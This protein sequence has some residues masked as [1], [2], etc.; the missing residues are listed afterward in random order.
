MPK[1]LGINESTLKKHLNKLKAALYPAGGRYPEALG[2]KVLRGGIRAWSQLGHFGVG[3]GKDYHPS[4]PPEMSVNARLH[5]QRY[6]QA[7]YAC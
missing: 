4:P 1:K 5:R 3:A 7:G 6:C 2:N